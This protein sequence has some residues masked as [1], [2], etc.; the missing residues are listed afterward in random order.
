M[1]III[2]AIFFYYTRTKNPT[3]LILARP[4][5]SYNEWIFLNFAP[6]DVMFSGWVGDQDP[7]FDG[8]KNALINMFHSAWN[9]YLNFGSDTGG[10]RGG[11]R[12]KEVFIRWSQ[13]STFCPLFEVSF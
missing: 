6:H 9:N 13:M 11:T 2:I 7:T 3:S 10:Y 8:L 1:Q 12:T 4:V 5:D